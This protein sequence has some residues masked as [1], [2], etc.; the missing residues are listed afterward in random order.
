MLALLQTAVILRLAIFSPKT[1]QRLNT[2]SICIPCVVTYNDLFTK[3]PTEPNHYKY[4]G[5]RDDILFLAN[6]EKV[7][8][9]PLE[10]HVQGNAG[11]EGALPVGNGRNQTTLLIEPID[12][13]G[14]HDHSGLIDRV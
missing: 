8:P 14:L 5:R 4:Y 12:E 7:H 1:L 6:G 10:Q 11:L 3:H 9:I 13:M 2:V